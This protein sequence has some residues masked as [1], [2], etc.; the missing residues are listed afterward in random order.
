VMLVS[1]G[2]ACT[3]W[4]RMSRRPSWTFGL[5]V[6]SARLPFLLAGVA[7]IPLYVLLRDT[8]DRH[9]ARMGA[10]LLALCPWAHHG[11]A[12]GLDSNLLPFVFLVATV[13]L[14]RSLRGQAYYCRRVSRMP[15]ALQL[16]NGVCRG[17][18]LFGPRRHLRPIPP[19]MAGQRVVKS[20]IA[21]AL[22][23][24]PIGLYV[25]INSLQWQSI[26]TPFFS[27]PRLPGVPRY[28]TNGQS[29]SSVGRVCQRAVANL[30]DAWNL[31][32]SQNDGLIWNGAT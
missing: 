2:R 25:L 31:F 15:R 3:R 9:T 27:I 23:A 30:K 5:S 12:L 17:A 19:S 28:Q 10:V 8:I 7:A 11:F 21:C 26:R 6:F 18:G 14:V 22:V 32:R 16:R 20:V 1:W 24:A 4:P 29:G 13:L